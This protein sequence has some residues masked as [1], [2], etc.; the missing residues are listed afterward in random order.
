MTFPDKHING[1]F[2]SMFTSSLMKT[3]LQKTHYLLDLDSLI[4]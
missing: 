1:C 4:Q 2:C 3:F